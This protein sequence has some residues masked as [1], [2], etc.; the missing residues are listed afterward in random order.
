MLQP[1]WTW[2]THQG[3][4]ARLKRSHI[5][6]CLLYDSFRIRRSR[7]QVT[8]VWGGE[9]MGSDYLM[10][11]GVFKRW[12]KSFET[13]ELIV[14]Q[15]CEYTKHHLTVIF[16]IFNCVINLKIYLNKKTKSNRKNSHT[17]NWKHTF[18]HS[19]LKLR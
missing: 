19:L 5:V 2:E 1:G 3:K 16:K 13:T 7:L 8:E 14:A 18:T 12:W 11:W 6:W 4:K 17:E 15:H 9:E 10:V